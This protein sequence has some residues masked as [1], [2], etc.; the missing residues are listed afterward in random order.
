M[1]NS[2]LPE[3][4]E[5]VTIDGS[6]QSTFAGQSETVV[7][8]GESAGSTAVGLEFTDS[9]SGSTV[10][11]LTIG[12]FGGGGVLVDG[13]SGVSI[14]NDDIGLMAAN[15]TVTPLGNGVFG[16]ELENGAN[17]N[18]L[19]DDVISDTTGTGVVITGTGTYDN[20]V[21]NSMVGTDPTGTIGYAGTV[22]L[23][24]TADG[25]AL[26]GGA[27]D[28]LL[29][30][31]VISNNAQYGVFISDPGTSGNV[32]GG[33]FIGTD[34]TGSYALPNYDGVFIQNGATDNTIGGQLGTLTPTPTPAAPRHPDD[35][36]DPGH[37]DDR[38]SRILLH[39]DDRSP[40]Q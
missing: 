11:D 9:A 24:N 10:N 15:S 38:P 4:T 22:S 2:P 36:F 19:S 12:G 32:V 35:H 28:N 29:S 37:P 14:T 21:E 7:I 13:A 31:D 3:I 1:L 33:S 30:S 34:V 6:T 26:S 5:P 27:S 20:V 8:M 39:R 18:T 23:G 25:V 16:V 17:Y 40:C